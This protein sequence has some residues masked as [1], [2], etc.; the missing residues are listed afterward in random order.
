MNIVQVAGHLGGDAETRF[1]P[2]GQK[3]VTFSVATKVRKNN[4]DHTIWWRVTIWGD[5]YD[6]MVPYL[7]KGTAIIVIGELGKP[8][9]WTGK[10]GQPQV[11]L[12]IRADIVRFSPFGKP[13]QRGAQEGGDAQPSYASAY[14]ASGSGSGEESYGGQSGGYGGQNGSGQRHG[15]GRGEELES[16]DEDLPF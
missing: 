10:D 5:R 2:S 3:I 7:K 15:Q 4:A 14:S 13:D 9:I 11:S 12:D 16:N 8:E 1:T 6:K